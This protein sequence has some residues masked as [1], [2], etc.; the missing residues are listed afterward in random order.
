MLADAL[1]AAVIAG[2]FAHVVRRPLF[3]DLRPYS[4]AD[5]AEGDD[6]ASASAARY[7]DDECSPLWDSW[8]SSQDDAPLFGASDDIHTDPE[9]SFVPGNI[10]HDDD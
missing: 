10:F 4:A 7:N 9:Y 3:D 2:L 1:I 5:D 8:C 6:T